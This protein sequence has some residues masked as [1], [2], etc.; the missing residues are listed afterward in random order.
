MNRGDD[1]KWERERVSE[2]GV[3]RH[4]KKNKKKI[5]VVCR[6]L[7]LCSYAEYNFHNIISRYLALESAICPRGWETCFSLNQKAYMYTQL[8][9]S[10]LCV[11]C[12][13]LLVS[14]SL[15][16]LF[17]FFSRKIRTYIRSDI[18]TTRWWT[19]KYTQTTRPKAAQ[20]LTTLAREKE[21]RK[22]R[23]RHRLYM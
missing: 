1:E 13:S 9:L 12:S 16:I 23:G 15:T 8:F 5:I 14:L 21:K 7:S 20:K 6:E 3:V 2:S 19:R 10:M 11:L 18:K 4:T 22:L 17:N